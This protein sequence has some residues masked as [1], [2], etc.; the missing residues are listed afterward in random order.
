MEREKEK[1]EEK[2]ERELKTGQTQA[3]QVHS[4]LGANDLRF[5][6]R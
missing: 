5:T 1:K 4:Q 6:R 2:K 3:S